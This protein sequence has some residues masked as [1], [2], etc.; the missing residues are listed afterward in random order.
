MVPRVMLKFR[1]GSDTPNAEA[2]QL[3]AYVQTRWRL[4]H[5][6]CIIPRPLRSSRACAHRR[7]LMFSSP[8]CSQQ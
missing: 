4:L 7:A 1:T 3:Y 5:E 6:R 8:S 2:Q